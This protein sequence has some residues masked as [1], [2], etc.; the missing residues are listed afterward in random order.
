MKKLLVLLTVLV[1]FVSAS[2]F[3]V[4]PPICPGANVVRTV[5]LDFI[6][7][8]GYQFVVSHSGYLYLGTPYPWLVAEGNITAATWQ[9]ALTVADNYLQ[10]LTGSTSYKAFPVKIGSGEI[11]WSCR[12]PTSAP[13]LSV[14]VST[15]DSGFAYNMPTAKMMLNSH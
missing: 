8:E 6:E 9:D 15:P 2:A 7:Q 12:Y 3:A 14:V 10:T 1:S 11:W 13:E 5:P 4:S